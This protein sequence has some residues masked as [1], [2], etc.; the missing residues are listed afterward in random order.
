MRLRKQIFYIA[1]PA[2]GG[3]LTLLL[4]KVAMKYELFQTLPYAL[5]LWQ[6]STIWMLMYALMGNAAYKANRYLR[7]KMGNYFYYI[8][9]FLS[10]LWMFL[11]FGGD[12]KLAF[13][14]IILVSGFSLC[15]MRE[16]YHFDRNAGYMLLPYILWL[17]YIAILN[18][19]V[20]MN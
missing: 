19:S 18:F 12:I 17:I 16:F 10:Y 4:C 9:L 13:A 7:D 5:L 20:C 3:L 15:T 1:L 2:A 14:V 11:L 8:Q 6:F